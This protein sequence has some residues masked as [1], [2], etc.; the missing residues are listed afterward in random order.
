M[1][2]ILFIVH[3]PVSMVGV[4]LHEDG[5]SIDWSEFEARI[6]AMK[7]PTRKTQRISRNLWLID[8]EVSAESL[9]TLRGLA[10]HFQLETSSFASPVPLTPM[11][12]TV[13][14]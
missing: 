6:S 14:W 1:N 2:Q 13:T 9:G 12:K 8:A 5:T 10:T 7:L 4:S 11:Q 3:L